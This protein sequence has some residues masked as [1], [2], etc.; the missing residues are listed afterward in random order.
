M[1][2]RFTWVRTKL[3]ELLPVA[4]PLLP[5]PSKV[6]RY[7]QISHEA[8]HYSNNGP[9][10]RM[11]KSE[12]SR[13]IEVDEDRL[14]LLSSATQCIQ[15]LVTLLNFESWR[16]PDYTFAASGTAVMSCGKKVELIDVD[17]ASMAV[18]KGLFSDKIA[19]HQQG[20]IV[21]MPFGSQFEASEWVGASN[22]IFDAAAS[23]GNLGKSFADLDNSSAVVFSLHATKVLG[24][25][26]GGL[27]VCGSASLAR[28]LEMWSQFGFDSSRTSVRLGTNAKISDFNCAVGLASLDGRRAELSRWKKLRKV[29][30]ELTLRHFELNVS[31]QVRGATPYWILKCES[32]A[33]A[34]ALEAFMEAR[35][36]QTRRWWPKPLSSMPLFSTE[37]EFGN[38][39]VAKKLAG[40]SLGL[41]FFREITP[42]NLIRVSETL[43]QFVQLWNPVTSKIEY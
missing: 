34:D 24:A 20:T 14:V 17:E 8:R 5:E 25:G 31:Q 16:V 2:P 40:S 22:V 23:L 36:I 42:E 32:S 37:A 28:D 13:L 26:E 4:R 10:L 3:D 6:A 29:T 15:G 19:N 27:A 43:D 9:V 38:N 1:R 12:L 18:P 33:Q 35:Q 30:N 39:P 41:P 7:L 11:Y 21:V